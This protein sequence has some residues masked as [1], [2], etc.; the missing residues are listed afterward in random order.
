MR[1]DKFKFKVTNKKTGDSAI[2]SLDDI[3]AYEGEVCGVLI[4]YDESELAKEYG[5][6]YKARPY[7]P[8]SLAGIAINYNSG[9]GFK[10]INEDLDFEY[11]LEE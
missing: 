3:Y 1:A 11:V 9:Y 2:I 8:N 6:D 7:I 10:G 5:D 4:G